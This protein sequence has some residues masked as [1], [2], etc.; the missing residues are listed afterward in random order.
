MRS[1]H[2]LDRVDTAFDG[3][4]L[5]ADAGMLLPATLALHLG[6]KGLVDRFL[7]LGRAAGR[8]NVGD[9]VLTLLM[10]ALAG[11]DCIDDADALCAGTTPMQT[12]MMARIAGFERDPFRRV[13]RRSTGGCHR[14][15]NRAPG[16][17]RPGW[18]SGWP[19]RAR[20]SGRRRSPG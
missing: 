8:S 20:S 12:L 16:R 2:S 4:Q 7:D 13:G 3:T 17:S 1:S 5:V 9:K 18:R 19:G 6:L 14:A 11:G 15:G 10:S